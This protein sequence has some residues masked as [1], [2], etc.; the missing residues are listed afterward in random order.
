VATQTVELVENDTEPSLDVTYEDI[1]VT[2]YESLELHIRYKPYPL[3]IQA[4]LGATENDFTFGWRSRVTGELA[5]DAAVGA[6]SVDVTITGDGQTFDDLPSSGEIVIGEEHV[7]YSAKTAPATLT[8]ASALEEAHT[9][10]EEMEKLPDLRAGVY[11]A[12]IEVVDADGGRLTFNELTLKID[13]E[14]A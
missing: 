7:L 12:E 11:K 9:E 4:T 5:A 1:D 8:L 6:T 10:G 3:T 13:E 2:D 14:I